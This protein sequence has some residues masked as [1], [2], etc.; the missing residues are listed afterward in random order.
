[1]AENKINRVVFVF[2]PFVRPFCMPVGISY[3]KSYAE[4]H[5][6]DIKFKCLD[7]N[8]VFH[9]MIF[10]HYKNNNSAKDFVDAFNFF[11]NNRE[12]NF[13]LKDA[14]KHSSVFLRVLNNVYS[15]YAS[16]FS[17]MINGKRHLNNLMKRM[18]RI[19]LK[20]K[21]DVVGI[22][23]NYDLQWH[24]SLV[25]GLIL[26][27]RGVKVVFGGNFFSTLSNKKFFPLS[28]DFAVIGEGENSF[29]EV[30]KSLN[31]NSSVDDVPGVM[32]WK[33]NSVIVNNPKPLEN[34]DSI[35][36]PDYSWFNP[37]EY[38]MPRPVLPILTS[39]G[40]YWRKCAFCVHHKNFLGYRQRSVENVIDELRFHLSCG[41][42][43]FNFVDEMISAQRF[44][45]ISDAVKKNNLNINF[46]GMAKP[47]KDF[48]YDIFKKMFDAGCRMM[49]WG[50]ESGNQRI[51]DLIDKGTKV[52]DMKKVLEDCSRAGIKNHV[53]LIFGFPTETYDELLDT[54]KFVKSNKDVLD[55]VNKGP[56]ALQ[57]GSE[58]FANPAKFGIT[59]I[60]NKNK[61]LNRYKYDVRSGLSFDEK[62][63]FAVK[64]A[65]FCESFNALPVYM[66]S[67][68]EHAL[69]VYSEKLEEFN[70]FKRN[71]HFLPK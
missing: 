5:L 15:K 13:D 9:D 21:P 37:R 52:E 70:K 68:R 38:F 62:E 71:V 8:S 45:Q 36:F 67:C 1:M 31:K 56:F 46:I 28:M 17:E 18:C 50:V 55:C 29:V 41:L 20:Q 7:L 54:L 48:T 51:L 47:T 53:F 14:E 30:I 26:K 39:R 60:H 22:S 59:N 19:V 16:F 2:P 10:E 57:A 23:V 42:R 64:F 27:Q 69:I 24:F 35:P 11:K 4:K 44:E 34:L 33:N 40:C 6:P 32:F 63:N 66:G 3:I 49:L 25:M 61:V 43:Y 12:I 65:D 58:V